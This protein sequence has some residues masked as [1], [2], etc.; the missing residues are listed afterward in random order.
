MKTN[1]IV[2]F[3]RK[4]FVSF[5]LGGLL[6]ILVPSWDGWGWH[7]GIAWGAKA[8]GWW[9]LEAK[10]NGVVINWYPTRALLNTRSHT[11]L[12]EVDG[13]EKREFLLFHSGKKYDIAIY[14]WTALAI[15][16]RHFWNRPIPKLLDNRFSCWEL[17]AEY[18]AAMNKPIVSKYDV[19]IITDILKHFKGNPC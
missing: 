6:K 1:D 19:I 7:L 10:A 18:C 14:F 4:G 9:I 5:V 13:R 11:W 12:D 2:E 8:D 15:I 3:K 17:V 16:I